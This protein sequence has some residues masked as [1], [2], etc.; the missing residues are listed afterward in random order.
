MGS[1]LYLELGDD[2]GARR[3]VIPA[4]HG[5]WADGMP[6][7][8]WWELQRARAVLAALGDPEPQLPPFDP[9]QIKP[10]SFE[11]KL[12]AYLEKK[13]AEK[14]AAEADKE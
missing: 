8:H 11:P 5:A 6:Y 14:E 3:H 7:V 1:E 13:K 4:F 2:A 12:L 10:F 9:S